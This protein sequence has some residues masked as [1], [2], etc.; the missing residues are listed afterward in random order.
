MAENEKVAKYPELGALILAARLKK[1][2]LDPAF[3]LRGFAAM[4]DLSPAYI[5]SL[6][7]GGAMPA[8]PTLQRIADA[9]DIPQDTLFSA[10]RKINPD[11]EQLLIDQPEYVAFLRS[12]NGLSEEAR[13]HINQIIHA[14][15]Q[16]PHPDERNA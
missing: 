6:E 15:N 13:E 2:Q 11:I 9:L 14:E 4:L 16:K 7:A 8:I 3:S 5:C 10:A 12:V 1:K